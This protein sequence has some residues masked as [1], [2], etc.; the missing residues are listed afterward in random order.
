[1]G[2]FMHRMNQ[3]GMALV[4]VVAVGLV[5]FLVAT[6]VMNLT[7]NRFNL[8]F[9]RTDHMGA[10]NATEAGVRYA[11]IRMQTDAVY[12]DPIFNAEGSPPPAGFQNAVVHAY[13]HTGFHGSPRAYVGT[14]L[15]VGTNPV[16]DGVSV[17]PDFRTNALKMG[18]RNVTVWIRYYGA[19]GQ[20]A[21]NPDFR[22]R[23]FSDYNT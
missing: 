2:G 17:T 3:K 19:G 15:P 9:V 20:G 7:Y 21:S 13:S 10:F 22:V 1:M 12:I 5:A 14:S 4:I 6:A 23:A 18:T 16:I 11:F 8:S